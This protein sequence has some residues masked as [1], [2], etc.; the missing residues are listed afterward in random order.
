MLPEIVEPVPTT[1]S[2]RSVTSTAT[3]NSSSSG[4]LRTSHQVVSIATIRIEARRRKP[5]GCRTSGM[6]RHRERAK[7]ALNPQPEGH[8]RIQHD[9]GL[10]KV[11]V[12]EVKQHLAVLPDIKKAD[13]AYEVERL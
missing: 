4:L 3:R 8:H 11:F 13:E 7:Y 5:V 6:R 9:Q 12:S 10:P 2:R 1:G